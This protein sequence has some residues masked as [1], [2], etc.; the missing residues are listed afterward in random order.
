MSAI[1]NEVL[2]SVGRDID[3][4]QSAAKYAADQIR[5]ARVVAT[6]EGIEPSYENILALAQLIATNFTVTKY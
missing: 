6:Q 3:Q 4:L 5:L 1:E 2:S